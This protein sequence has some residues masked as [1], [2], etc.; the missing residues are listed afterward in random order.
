[1]QLWVGGG[2]PLTTTTSLCSFYP[3][4]WH[5]K[6]PTRRVLNPTDRSSWT[7]ANPPKRNRPLLCEKPSSIFKD[8]QPKSK[9]ERFVVLS[10]IVC[11][12]PT[13]NQTVLQ[14]S[15]QN[16]FSKSCSLYIVPNGPSQFLLHAPGRI[17]YTSYNLLHS[18][19]NTTFCVCYQNTKE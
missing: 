14:C 1:M 9:R 12:S 5:L 2:W 15:L 11:C 19:T 6:Q 10:T 16:R 17:F 18:F 4:L 3:L 13:A 7:S 8:F